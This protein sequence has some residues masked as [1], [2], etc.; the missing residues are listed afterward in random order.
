MEIPENRDAYRKRCAFL[1]TNV[2]RADTIN[3][4][5][6]QALGR[7]R[8]AVSRD[9]GSAIEHEAAAL[10]ERIRSRVAQIQKQLQQVPLELLHFQNGVAALGDWE[11]TDIPE[12]GE[13]NRTT[14]ADGRNALMIRAGP[15]TSASWRT[16]VLLPRGRYRLEGALKTAGV[17]RLKFGKNHGAVLKAPGASSARTE[18]LLGSQPWKTVHLPFEVTRREQEV[19]LVC[20]LRAGKGTAWFDR[21]SLRLVRVE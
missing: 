19:E 7:L 4:R 3:R 13:L 17:E 8:P 6:D 11:A 1:A 20:E 9:A 10:K 18:P 12:G 21:D 14:T 5:I 16:K 15:V 2:L